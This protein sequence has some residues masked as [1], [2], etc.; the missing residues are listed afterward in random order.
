MKLSA[1]V[2][3]RYARAFYDYA[4][5]TQ[6][7]DQ[8]LVDARVLMQAVAQSREVVDFLGN[9]VMPRPDRRRVLTA[10]F[11]GRVHPALWRMILFLEEKR[12]LAW[13]GEVCRAMNELWKDAQG[14]VRMSLYS[15]F[16][17]TADEMAAARNGFQ[18]RLAQ[19]VELTTVCRP[20]LLAGVQVL[21][22]DR[23]YDYSAAGALKTFRK[24][25]LAA[26]GQVNGNTNAQ[27]A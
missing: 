1:R 7:L 6:C 8:V 27:G 20:E 13:L 24:R 22:N 9:T 25:A 3:R 26:R 10:V 2:T 5:E 17:R 14:I 4:S 18:A 16:D 11:G 21:V 23:F 19:P 15:A 12:R